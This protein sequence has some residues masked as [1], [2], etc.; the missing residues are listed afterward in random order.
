MH[1]LQAV[2]NCRQGTPGHK[3]NRTASI[4]HASCISEIYSM[5]SFEDS[6]SHLS[7]STPWLMSIF[8]ENIAMQL[9][10]AY[11]LTDI[12]VAHV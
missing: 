10:M 2:G 4:L 11:N 9:H 5:L 3:A 6:R 7:S 1:V 12:N 8:I